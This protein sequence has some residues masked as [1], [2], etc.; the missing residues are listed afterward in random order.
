MQIR[1]AADV[2]GTLSS[3]AGGV[4]GAVRMRGKGI[5]RADRRDVSQGREAGCRGDIATD[6]H[7]RARLAANAI[8][9]VVRRMLARLGRLPVMAVVTMTAIGMAPHA[10]GH[11]AERQHQ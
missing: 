7:R 1:A 3:G 2:Q 5:H 11:H 9:T 10:R 8:A 6:F 4:K